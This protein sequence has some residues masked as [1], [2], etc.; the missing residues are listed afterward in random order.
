MKNFYIKGVFFGGVARAVIKFA[1]LYHTVFIKQL[2]RN[3]T[4][5]EQTMMVACY[6]EQRS[7]FYLYP[8]HESDLFNMFRLFY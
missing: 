3:F 8:S 7:L 2:R 4:D 1:D 5:D 6:V